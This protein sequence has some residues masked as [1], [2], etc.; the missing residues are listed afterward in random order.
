MASQAR[1]RS[2]SE[3]IPHDP[4]AVTS[5]EVRPATGRDVAQIMCQVQDLSVEVE[6]LKREVRGL[7]ERIDHLTA[8]LTRAREVFTW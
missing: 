8:M 2:S 3:D 6:S 7:S 5:L 1:E 4:L